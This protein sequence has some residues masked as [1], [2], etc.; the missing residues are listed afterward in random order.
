M[1]V[2]EIQKNKKRD[3]LFEHVAEVCGIDIHDLTKSAR[4]ALNKAVSE[5][6]EINPTLAE[7]RERVEVYY[8]RHPDCALTP[9]ALVKHWPQL[10]PHNQRSKTNA[11]SGKIER[12][13]TAINSRRNHSGD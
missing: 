10:S 8:E 11:R 1:T 9:L 7:L 5:L 12:A 13:I 2:V 6:R 4:G 3:E